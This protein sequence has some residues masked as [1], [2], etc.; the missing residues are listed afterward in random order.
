MSDDAPTPPTRDAYVRVRPTTHRRIFDL[1]ERLGTMTADELPPAL[2]E[3][4]QEELSRAYAPEARGIRVG[5]VVS[6]ALT[7]LEEALARGKGST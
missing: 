6:L 3:A 5:S 2:A 1:R 7:A 4:W